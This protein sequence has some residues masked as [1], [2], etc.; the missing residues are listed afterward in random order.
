[1][2][3]Q[4]VNQTPTMH[5]R[6]M[7]CAGVSTWESQPMHCGSDSHMAPRGELSPPFRPH[8]TDP[9]PRNGYDAHLTQKDNYTMSI[10]LPDMDMVTILG[11]LTLDSQ[12]PCN[13][14]QLVKPMV[15]IV[16]TKCHN[17]RS[18]TVDTK[19]H[20]LPSTQGSDGSTQ[21]AIKEGSVATVDT[22]GKCHNLGFTQGSD[23]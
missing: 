14:I 15:V 10:G 2:M 8:H 23:V 11:T 12:S 9:R 6:L 7:Q 20:S 16:D 3:T 19:C 22:V 17:L 4:L 5:S 21:P 13:Y 1:M 18:S